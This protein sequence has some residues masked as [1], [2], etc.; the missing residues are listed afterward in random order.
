MSN[1]CIKRG[2]ESSRSGLLP[3]PGELILASDT[4]RLYVG[5]GVTAGGVAI[6]ASFTELARTA[7]YVNL[8]GTNIMSSSAQIKYGLYGQDLVLGSITASNIQVTNLSVVNVTASVVYSSGSNIFGNDSTNVHQFTGS[9]SMTGSLTISGALQ[10]NNYDAGTL[11][12]DQDGNITTSTSPTLYG[13]DLDQPGGNNRFVRFLTSGSSRWTVG[14]GD[15]LELGANTGSNLEINRYD[16]AGGY[17]DT[18][19]SINRSTGKIKIGQLV[20]RGSPSG[21]ILTYDEKGEITEHGRTIIPIPYATGLRIAGGTIVKKTL[22]VVGD[23]TL[24]QDLLTSSSP[25]FNAITAS[26]DLTDY[27]NGQ[28]V[29][30]GETGSVNYDKTLSIGFHTADNV[31]FVQSFI[32]GDTTY[33]FILNPSGGNVG[34]GTTTPGAKLEVAGDIKTSAPSG[35]TSATWKFG[36]YSSGLTHVEISGSSVKLVDENLLENLASTVAGIASN[37][38]S[39]EDTETFATMTSSLYQMSASIATLTSSVNTLEALESAKSPLTLTWASTSSF[40]FDRP[41]QVLWM[42]GDTNVVS[43]N[44]TAGKKTEI[45]VYGDEVSRSFTYPAWTWLN[46]GPPTGGIDA[47]MGG[48]L[49][50]TCF[51][52]SESNILAHFI[53]FDGTYA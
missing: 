15:D 3:H 26:Y 34:V 12:S 16:D 21:S 33:P 18:P 39:F 49:K 4:N 44:R 50:L 27:N 40:S 38:N 37:L 29:V 23:T 7:S 14:A 47:Y 25:K 46:P 22:T 6:T 30:K 42:T 31:G 11:I 5:D 48:L 35:G 13:V 52:S 28:I 8:T 53:P 2:L 51:G 41:L 10:L 43:S 20:G 36:S 32:A 19:I 9:V 1:I 45:L 17:L 24:N